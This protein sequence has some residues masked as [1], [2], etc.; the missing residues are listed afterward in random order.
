MKAAMLPR[1]SVQFLPRR[2]PLSGLMG[3]V[4]RLRSS[5]DSYQEFIAYDEHF[6]LSHRLGFASPWSAWL[7]NPIIQSS[8]DPFDYAIR[9]LTD[10]PALARQA[11]MQAVVR[12]QARVVG[13][14][15]EML[16]ILNSRVRP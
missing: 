12:L 8:T 3:N 1:K 15:R 9:D 14:I 5:Y 13:N 16:A 2:M 11:D 4:H 7:T 10:Y 6:R